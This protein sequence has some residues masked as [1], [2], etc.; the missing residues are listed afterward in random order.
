MVVSTENGT[1]RSRIGERKTIELLAATGFDAVDYGFSPWFENGEMPWN[2]DNYK[3]YAKEVNLMMSDNGLYFNQAH[4]PFLFHTE[5]F[6]DYS[7][8]VMPL[9]QR[10]FEVCAM[11]NVPHMVVHPIHYLPYRVNKE[12]MWDINF[13]FYNM[14]LPLSKE[15]GVK[16][17]LENMYQYDPR[18]GVL[19][20]DVF[21]HPD[22]YAK[23][24]D[25][26]NDPNFICLIDTGHC[27]I[28]GENAP[29]VIRI[30][31]SRVKALH[32][33]DNLYRTD[34]HLIPGIGIMDWNEITKALADINYSGDI[35]FEVLNTF[36][37]Y[38]V[39][40]L[41][42]AL[43]YLLDVGRYIAGKIEEYK[44]TEVGKNV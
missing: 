19:T 34:D 10:C 18:R 41:P 26:L 24:Y 39:S 38:D 22:M 5:Y 36:K 4:G 37:A 35:T 40:F 14:L 32:V 44:N 15:Y 28:V 3:E 31:G 20:E 23:F 8:E 25:T 13:E 42:V 7:R 33:N 21:S 17:A 16:I 2:T 9:F 6:P 29:D 1:L 43:K 30:M 12:K 27:S 11:L